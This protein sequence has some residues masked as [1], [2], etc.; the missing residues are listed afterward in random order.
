[1]HSDP[2]LVGIQHPDCLGAAGFSALSCLLLGSRKA[3]LKLLP[4]INLSDPRPHPKEK[5]AKKGPKCR[6]LPGSANGVEWEAFEE[7]GGLHGVPDICT[8]KEGKGLW[9]RYLPL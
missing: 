6:Q 4:P 7:P 2:D 1:M 9:R 8:L 3:G 5:G